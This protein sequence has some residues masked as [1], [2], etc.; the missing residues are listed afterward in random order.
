VLVVEREGDTLVWTIDRPEARNA[1]DHATL[2]ALLDAAGEAD[3]DPTVRAIVLTAGGQTFVSGGDLRA[4][5]GKNAPE[6]AARFSDVGWE[7]TQVMEELRVPIVCALPG[8]AIGG[9][10]ELA[11][12]CD[13]RVADARGSLSFKQVRMGVTTA[14]GTVPRLI[15]LV[16]RG[17]A[18][19]LL[20]TASEVGVDEAWRIGLVDAVTSEGRA[21]STALAWAGEIAAGS[22]RAVADMKRLVRATSAAHPSLR[23]LERQA[24]IDTWSHA[25]HAEAVEAH[26]ERRRPLWTPLRE[27]REGG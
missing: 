10:A 13:L 6:D 20:Y 3:R 12:A 4:L 7:L 2:Q 1:L 16:G 14:W 22:P 19:R 9:G 17:A 15:A 27:P 18:A 11:L 21:K 24:F 25:D 5:R 26:F 8:P 23:A